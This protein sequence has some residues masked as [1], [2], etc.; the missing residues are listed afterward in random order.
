MLPRHVRGGRPVFSPWKMAI[1]WLAYV[2]VAGLGIFK[3]KGVRLAVWIPGN[4]H[5]LNR[6]ASALRWALVG[7]AALMVWQGWQ[8]TM[9][10]ISDVLFVAVGSFLL[11][12]FLYIPDTAFHLSNGLDRIVRRGGSSQNL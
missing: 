11:I 1:F 6:Q 9:G 3:G 5:A 10:A 12:V 7:V 2:V 8:L 4:Q